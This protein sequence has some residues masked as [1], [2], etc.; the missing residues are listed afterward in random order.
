MTAPLNK[1]A[2][3]ELSVPQTHYLK[4]VLR[5][6]QN[7][8]VK[9]F[10]A[11]SGEW[12]GTIQTKNKKQWAV[13]LTDQTHPPK[14]EPDIWLLFAPLKKESTDIV[15][16]KAT[17]LGASV[18]WPVKTEFT[19]TS[20][21]NTERLLANTIE[22]AEQS[23]RLSIPHIAPYQNLSEALRLIP[24]ERTI[25]YADAHLAREAGGNTAS[26]LRILENLNKK[27]SYAILVGPEGGFSETEHEHL[28]NHANTISLSL[29][30]RI[31]KAETAAIALLSC[32]QAI[33]GDW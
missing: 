1:D 7:D 27:E 15:I 17:E 28:S 4:N 24:P 12:H 14:P 32:W 33:C 26:L 20:R 25:L 11:D 9:L 8:A 2:L 3:I 29:G 23:E 10:N 6:N 30:P 13:H 5:R 21:I 22:A 31:L 16:K 19:N 18:L